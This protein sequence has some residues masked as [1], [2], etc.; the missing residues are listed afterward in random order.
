M[1]VSKAEDVYHNLKTGPAR[2]K[3]MA[4]GNWGNK[5]KPGEVRLQGTFC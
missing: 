5:D 4:S 3:L 1:T 2:M